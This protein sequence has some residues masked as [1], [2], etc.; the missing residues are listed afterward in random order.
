MKT[1]V[2]SFVLFAGL[3]FAQAPAV[4]PAAVPP[5]AVPPGGG[6]GPQAPQVVSPEVLPDHSV[7]FRILAPQAETVQL[8]GGD[9]PQLMGGGR[10]APPN[11]GPTFTKDDKGVW[12]ATLGPIDPGAYR[13]NFLVNGVTVIDPRNP[14]IS[15]SNTN[16]WSLFTVPGSDLFDTKNVPHGA[17]AAVTYYST[18]LG[19]FR[20]MHVYTPP[21]YEAGTQKYP[22]FY[23]LHGAG[24]SDEAWTSV[25]RAGFIL[26]NLLAANKTKPM[27]V[28]MPA[29]HTTRTQGG[30]GAAATD[31]FTADFVTDVMPYIEKNYRSINDRAHRAIAGLSMGG[32]QTLNIAFLHLDKFAYIGV[33]SSGILGGGGAEAWEKA[34]LADLDNASLKKGLKTV[35]FSTGVN[36]SLITNSKSTVE[37]LKKHG[38]D[39]G[40]KESPGA[41][42][43]INWRNYLTE[44]TP[45]LFQ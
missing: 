8:R 9:I 11:L 20:R 15:E 38:F 19:R 1:L 37:L 10:G 17:V 5:A 34:H 27:I 30:G 33:F 6:R 45:L 12:E 4:P 29:G 44:F 36:D 32:S 28:V 21:G 31:E 2:C 40:F 3:G 7:T 42:T 18:A 24:D 43:W 22:V 41:H 35:W 13:Y 39:A 14:S 16:V 26:D 23:L 25:G